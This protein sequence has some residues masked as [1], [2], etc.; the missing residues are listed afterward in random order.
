LDKLKSTH[1][2]HQTQTCFCH[3]LALTLFYVPLG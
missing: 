3:F 1:L 2:R